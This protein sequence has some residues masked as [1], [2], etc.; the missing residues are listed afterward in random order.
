MDNGG[1]HP[2]LD[3]KRGG[4]PPPI[5]SKRGGVSPSFTTSVR[6]SCTSRDVR[7]STTTAGKPVAAVTYAAALE[8]LDWFAAT[9]PQYN[10]GARVTVDVE[11]DGPVVVRLLTAP[12][13]D[14][15]RLRAMAVVMWTATAGED[16][17]VAA[18]ADR[19]LRLLNHSA[20]R[21][22]RI[23]VARSAPAVAAAKPCLYKHNPPCSS[24]SACAD[25]ER[26]RIA[27]EERFG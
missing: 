9:Y 22:E 2:L 7:T 17:W 20:D 13:R 18:A 25:F 4:N 11:A 27:R 1:I 19:G 15:E 26:E 23:A 24:P 3:E 5:A 6:T 12:Q 16:P 14:V 8:F 10:N 21:L